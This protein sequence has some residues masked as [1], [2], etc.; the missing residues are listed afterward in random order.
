MR[1]RGGGLKNK[2]H[3]SWAEKKQAPCIYTNNNTVCLDIN[4]LKAEKSCRN[5]KIKKGVVE[6]QKKL[7]FSA[8]TQKKDS[9]L[10]PTFLR[11]DLTDTAGVLENKVLGM[12]HG[13]DN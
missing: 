3:L 7:L 8:E 4:Q 2:P 6:N 5:W 1:T 11:Y 9:L 13:L 10:L 12:F